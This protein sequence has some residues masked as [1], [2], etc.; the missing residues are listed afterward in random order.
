MKN[1]LSHSRI[2]AIVLIFIYLAQPLAAVA[3]S[4]S[5]ETGFSSAAV[6]SDSA[7]VSTGGDCPCSDEYDSGCCDTVFCSCSC[8]AS[9]ARTLQ[10]S[11]S[12]MIVMQSFLEPSWPLPQVYDRI[13]VPPQNVL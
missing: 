6:I 7:A 8:H 12:P 13:F 3:H 1:A 4:V 10:I 9:L 2:I 5:L 11:Y